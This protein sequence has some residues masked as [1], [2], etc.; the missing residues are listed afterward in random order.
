MKNVCRFSLSTDIETNPGPIFH[1]DPSKTV[2]APY[3][4]GNRVIFGETA[5]QQC[6]AMCLCALIYNKRQ[7]ISSSQD[8][9]QIMN[10]GNELYSNL[11]HLARQS[12]LMFTELPSYLTVFE[13]DYL[14]TYSESHSGR[15]TGECHIEGYQY[16][17]PF[18]R[19]F[20]LLLTESYTAFILTVDSNAVC[21]YL[22]NDGKVKIFDSH[23]RDKYG[24]SHPLGMCVLLE[25]ETIN[26]VILHF[27]SLSNES[28]N[29]N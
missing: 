13:T 20:E 28:V 29:L 5:G 23:S 26:N 25:A 21:I 15:V 19:A 10:I 22:S 24:K 2:C 17:V 4:Q 27:Q 14:L 9:I 1:V 11:S 6:L 8:L 3:S 18:L 16:C 7:G 12:F